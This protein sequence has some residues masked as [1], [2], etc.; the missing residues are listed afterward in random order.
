[1]PEAPKKV[2]RPIEVTAGAEPVKLGSMLLTVVEPHRGHEVDYN[3]WY[4]RDHFYA[5]CMVGPYNFAGR[6]FVA[7]RE[8]KALRDPDPSE[9]TG[10]PMRGSYMALYW[11]LDGYHD[12]WN[13]WAVRQ[14]RA[15]HAAGRMFE[16]RDHVHTLLYKFSWEVVSD[17]DGVPVEL[18]LDHPFNGLVAIWIDRSAATKAEDLDHWLRH[19]H[20]PALLPATDAGLVASF[21]PLPLLIDAPGDVPRQD[22]DD[23]RTLL[24]WFFKTDPFHAWEAAIASHRR[25]IE[26]SGLAT[27][28][29]ALPFI[30][31]IPGTDTYTDRLWT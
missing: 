25:S 9:I 14:V 28:V 12:I 19:E 10:E 2:P 17:T 29:A 24:L 21:S 5:G 31:T 7:T 18:A 30:P 6:R 22:A 8:L 23:R 3:R 1:M 16:H 27:V 26:A 4:E 20:L 13:R 15:L 11:V